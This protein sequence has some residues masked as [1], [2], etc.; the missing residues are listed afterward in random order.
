MKLQKLYLTDNAP[1]F[2]WMGNSNF[3][4]NENLRK[5]KKMEIKA[6]TFLASY[7]PS[8]KIRF[9]PEITER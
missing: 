3:M 9:Y 4:I 1:V 5:S 8:L 6:T 2:N 7:W